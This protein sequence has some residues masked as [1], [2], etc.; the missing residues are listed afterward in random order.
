MVHLSQY[1]TYYRKHAITKAYNS[2]SPN[3][4]VGITSTTLVL[5][6]IESIRPA[7]HLKFPF[8]QLNN[9]DDSIS[10]NTLS[11]FL[12]FSSLPAY[13]SPCFFTKVEIFEIISYQNQI[14][15]TRNHKKKTE[16]LPETSNHT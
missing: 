4:A 13:E 1:Y 10:L 11:K 9:N 6:C 12:K 7:R 3:S 5:F 15:S 2:N 16:W 14:R 8:Q